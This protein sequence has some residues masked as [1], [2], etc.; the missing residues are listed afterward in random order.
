MELILIYQIAYWSKASIPMSQHALNN[1]AANARHNNKQANITGFLLYGD[2]TFFQIIEGQYSDVERLYQK[3]CLD[4]R[5]HSPKKIGEWCLDTRQFNH[6]AMGFEQLSKPTC[7]NQFAY[8]DRWRENT[9]TKDKFAMRRL[10]LSYAN[11]AELQTGQNQK[12]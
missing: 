1:L 11:I 7:I 10:L 8:L 5:H 6:W 3:I 2:N 4:D 9:L 12:N